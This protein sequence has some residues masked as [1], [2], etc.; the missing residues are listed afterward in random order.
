MTA[1]AHPLR[2]HSPR[3]VLLI[4]LHHLSARRGAQRGRVHAAGRARRVR[5][6]RS[7]AHQ[8]PRHRLYRPLARRLAGPLHVAPR[9]LLQAAAGQDAECSDA[10]HRLPPPGVREDLVLV[11][12]GRAGAQARADGLRAADPGEERIPSP[13]GGDPSLLVLRSHS[14]SCGRT[15]GSRTTC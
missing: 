4:G 7:R 6:R 14:P 10:G 11:G 9:R 1:V 13:R 3:K 15:S 5:L 2:P 12:G 8:G